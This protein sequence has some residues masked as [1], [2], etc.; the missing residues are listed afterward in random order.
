MFVLQ[1]FEL[2][3]VND[4]ENALLG[5]IRHETWKEASERSS[6]VGDT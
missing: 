5:S 3:P 2:I 6:D 4:E 1:F